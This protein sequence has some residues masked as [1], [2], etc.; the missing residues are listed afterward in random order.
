MFTAL[1]SAQ[2]PL[3][4]EYRR[5]AAE[6]TAC[7][8]GSAN[9]E[10]LAVPPSPSPPP[11]NLNATVRSPANLRGPHHRSPVGGACREGGSETGGAITLSLTPSRGLSTP[12]CAG[13]QEVKR[14]AGGQG[15]IV[16]VSNSSLDTHEGRKIRCV[17]LTLK[18]SV[19]GIVGI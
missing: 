16:T 19:Q 7:G 8:G 2:C 15:N 10:A 4:R 11:A 17:F 1:G 12:L 5:L 3:M 13:Q 9:G 14:E 6:E 18:S